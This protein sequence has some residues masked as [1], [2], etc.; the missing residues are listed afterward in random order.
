MNIDK[1]KSA[2]GNYEIECVWKTGS[3]LYAVPHDFDF[4]V[5]IKNWN[6]ERRNYQIDDCD[7]FCYS[8]SERNA[9]C[10]SLKKL[11]LFDECY[12]LN[13]SNITY[14]SRL[15][16]I[17]VLQNKQEYAKMIIDLADA[18]FNSEWAAR[19]KEKYC[20]T[21]LINALIP[22]YWVENGLYELN[23][24]QK[25]LIKSLHDKVIEYSDIKT[26]ISYVLENATKITYQ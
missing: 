22:I 23:E 9:Q 15:P 11:N 25:T 3:Q 7:Y 2:I 17:L 8:V 18:T 6:I 24:T 20:S 1:L 12:L 13:S 19:N 10:L 26:L 21:N 14:G 16:A 5:T 4:I